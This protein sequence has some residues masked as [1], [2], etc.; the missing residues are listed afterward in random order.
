MLFAKDA[1]KENVV[2]RGA[3]VIDPVEG[4]QHPRA[5]A[6]RKAFPRIVE[7]GQLLGVHT[8]EQPERRLKAA[9]LVFHRGAADL[10]KVPRREV[11]AGEHARAHLGLDRQTLVEATG[12]QQV[13]EQ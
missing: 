10:E 9:E 12:D 2:V 13:M 4:G 1:A 5:I 11:G 6:A 3:R 8:I 7:T